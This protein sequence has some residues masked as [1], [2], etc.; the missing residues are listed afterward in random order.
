MS[1]L[2]NSNKLLLFCLVVVLTYAVGL[3]T[4][5]GPEKV[6]R[7]FNKR[8]VRPVAA[9]VF[10]LGPRFADYIE[11]ECPDSGV[12]AIAYNRTE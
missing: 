4:G 11:K 2:K 8:L 7:E 12:L 9:K 6:F 1:P 3:T 10:H 5:I